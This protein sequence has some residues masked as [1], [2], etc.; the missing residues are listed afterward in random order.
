ME[1]MGDCREQHIQTHHSQKKTAK[2]TP[3][4]HSG[5]TPPLPLP[6]FKTQC[7]GA[8]MLEALH[9]YPRKTCPHSACMGAGW[10]SHLMLAH[11]QNFHRY[12]WLAELRL[13]A[14]LCFVCLFVLFCF[15]AALGL[16]C[17]VRAF[18]SC[19]ERDLLFVAAC[20][21]S[22]VA[23]SRGYSS[24]LCVGSRAHGLQWL[25]LVGSVVVAYGL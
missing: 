25:W 22:L 21:L 1:S 19:S 8:W 10:S 6:P 14:W 17:C 24:L 18:S 16:C 13:C 20:R 2:C 7:T 3:P 4:Y 12:I 5:K 11:F 23:V 9:S 15:L